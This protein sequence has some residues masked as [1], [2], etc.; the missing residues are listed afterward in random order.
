MDGQ[1]GLFS[2]IIPTLNEGDLLAMTVESIIAQTK[3]PHFEI[4][5]VD[6]GSSDRSCDPFLDSSPLIR[7]IRSPGLGVAGARNVGAQN[8]AGEYITF[9]DAHCRVAPNWLSDFAKALIPPDVGMVGPCFTKLETPQ[10]RGCGM[11]WTGY[12]LDLSWF[13]PV[14][15]PEPYSVPLTTGACQAF[16]RSLFL[17]TG[18]Y[19]EGFTRWGFEDVEMCLRLWLL[20]FRVVVEPGV[21]VAHYFRESRN[22][23]V[24]HTDVTYN[25]LRMIHLHF[26]AKR[27]RS[28]LKAVSFNPFIDAA[29]GKLYQSD[30]FKQRAVL[31]AVRVRDDDWF[32]S[33]VNRIEHDA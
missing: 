29:L 5:I 30:I 14:D 2:I 20:G 28:V 15:S 22:Y 16:R 13:E 4:I 24:D 9:L 11:M 7:V 12:T 32:F 33:I 18:A 31:E 6:D 8:A 23:D 1:N 19:E 3:Y 17:G 27:I 21:T 25:F 26:S 10:P